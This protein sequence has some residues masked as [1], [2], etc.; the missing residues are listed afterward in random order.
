MIFNIEEDK[1]SEAVSCFTVRLT[2]KFNIEEDRLSEAVSCSI[3]SSG[4]LCFWILKLRKTYY[5]KRSPASELAVSS[6]SD[7]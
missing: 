7:I 3:V 2:M 1:L 5:P 4:V 6:A